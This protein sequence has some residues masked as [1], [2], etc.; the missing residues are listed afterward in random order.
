[1]NQV[2]SL[3]GLLL[4]VVVALLA[5]K[6]APVYYAKYQFEDYLDQ[7]AKVE[8]YTP[9]SEEMIAETIAKRAQEL[10]I[11]LT[12]G[13]I[14]VQRTGTDLTV[15]ADYTVTIDVPLRPFEMSFHIATQNR[16]I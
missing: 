4:I 16:K 14:K 5:W 10:G 8:S 9:H 13:D 15:Q 11:P 6:I 2:K 3:F 12:A 1:M 7:Q